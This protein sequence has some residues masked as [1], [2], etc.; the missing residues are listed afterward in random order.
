MMCVLQE[1]I[2]WRWQQKQELGTSEALT[3]RGDAEL[4]EMDIDR[5]LNELQVCIRLVHIALGGG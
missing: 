1:N 4:N 2:S 5:R 3:L